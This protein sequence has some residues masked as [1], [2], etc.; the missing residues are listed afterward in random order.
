MLKKRIS[1]LTSPTVDGKLQAR[2]EVDSLFFLL[3]VIAPNLAP[4]HQ[5]LETASVCPVDFT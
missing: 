5:G 2:L 4:S 3:I 1:Y